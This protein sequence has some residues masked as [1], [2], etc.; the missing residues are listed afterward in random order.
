MGLY[1]NLPEEITEV[2]IIIAG[3]KKPVLVYSL[4]E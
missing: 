4:R 3:G 2:D 1:T